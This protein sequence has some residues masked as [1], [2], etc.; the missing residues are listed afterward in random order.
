M[1]ASSIEHK[2]SSWKS[3]WEKRINYNTTITITSHA[4]YGQLYEYSIRFA[5]F[6]QP[7]FWVS[8]ELTLVH[9]LDMEVILSLHGHVMNL[10]LYWSD[11]VRCS[12]LCSVGFKDGKE[13]K[14]P[15]GDNSAYSDTVHEFYM[16]TEVSFAVN[17]NIYERDDM[18]GFVSTLY[19]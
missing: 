11:T 19:A 9:E 4:S 16:L 2:S 8:I 14:I 10:E 12:S 5:S 6:G 1:Y 17:K 3:V 7:V 18:V 13:L 15:R